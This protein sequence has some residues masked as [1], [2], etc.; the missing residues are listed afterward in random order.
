M[1]RHRRDSIYQPFI[2]IL[3][4]CCIPLFFLS[5]TPEVAPNNSVAKAFYFWKQ[6]YNLTAAEREVMKDHAI[7]R[8]YIKLFDVKKSPNGPIPVAEVSMD[9]ASIIAS[10]EYIPTVFITEAAIS[11]TS[12]EMIDTLAKRIFNKID[13]ISEKNKLHPKEIQLDCDWTRSTKEK[14]FALVRSIKSLAAAKGIITSCTIRLHQIKYRGETGI[15]PADRGMLMFYNMSD[16]RSASTKNS[17]F[18]AD[19][20]EKYVLYIKDYPLTLDCALPIFRWSIA[21]RS[22]KVLSILSSVDRSAFTSNSEF[23]VD[24]SRFRVSR[25]T[26]AYGIKL[27]AGDSIRPESCDARELAQWSQRI[28]AL[29]PKNQRSFALYHLDSVT[30]SHYSYED[31]EHLFP[32]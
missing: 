23:E 10:V 26:I 4:C 25:D 13:R 16:W 11:S 21:Y 19:K 14:Y 24:G 12:W 17:I 22:G 9:S 29:L 3:V 18:D 30:L 32:R 15:P 2:L 8:L 1:K 28:Q 27:E 7:T 5:C 31:L 20:A 6:E